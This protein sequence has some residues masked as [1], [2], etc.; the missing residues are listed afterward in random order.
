MHPWESYLP[1][2]TTDQRYASLETSLQP[3]AQ[4]DI[5]EEYCKEILKERKAAKESSTGSADRVGSGSGQSA[6]DGYRKLLKET[7][8]STRTTY[9]EFRQKV[10]KERRFYSYGRD[11]KEREREFRS[12]HLIFH[13]PDPRLCL[14]MHENY[15]N[16]LKELGEIKKNERKKAEEAFLV[17]LKES[18]VARTAGLSGTQ[19]KWS[20]V[21]KEFQEDLRYEAVGSSTLREELYEVFLKSLKEARM[22]GAIEV[23]ATGNTIE[24]LAR[25]E[26]GGLDGEADSKPSGG[27]EK[28][29][30]REKAVRE[31]EERVHL[32]KE[33]TAREN[34]RGRAGLNLEEAE[35]AFRCVFYC[36]P[37]LTGALLTF[38]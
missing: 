10:K 29:R 28:K 21:K 6:H 4:R 1:Q 17:M 38:L 11:E 31:R 3:P 32:E 27:D 13:P 22:K 12:V 20:E 7:V 25:P 37:T 33:R 2:I 24:R 15:R 9:T 35:L 26:E 36:T 30:R 16:Y 14:L 5:F 18:Q 19:T 34:A 23:P 8:T